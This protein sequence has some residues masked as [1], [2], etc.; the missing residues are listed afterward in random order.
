MPRRASTCSVG[1]ISMASHGQPSRKEPSGP[2]L[3]HFLQ[4]IQVAGSTSMRPKGGWSGSGTQYM[5]SSTGQY[6][7]HA[8]EPAH[9]VQHSV[10][11]ANSFGFFLRGV[12]RPLDLGSNF[13]SSGTI[14]AGSLTTGGAAIVRIIPESQN[15]VICLFSKH[16]TAKF[17]EDSQRSQSNVSWRSPRDLCAPCA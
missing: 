4:P 16:L 1:T 2:L 6:S 10:I 13:S 12:V 5:Q 7:T 9:P 14:P 8:G 3:V 11:T 15:D 17:I